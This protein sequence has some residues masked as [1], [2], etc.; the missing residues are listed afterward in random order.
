MPSHSERVKQNY[1]EHHWYQYWDQL[2]IEETKLIK[3][4]SKCDKKI[5]SKPNTI[6]KLGSI[7]EVDGY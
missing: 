7:Q 6:I 1:C 2:G 5:I 4:C 3:Q